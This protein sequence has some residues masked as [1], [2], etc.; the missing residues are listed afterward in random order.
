M[1]TETKD[2]ADGEN[3]LAHRKAI[4]YLGLILPW[5]LMLL[6]TRGLTQLAVR[7]TISDYYYSHFGSVFIGILFTIGFALFTYKGYEEPNTWIT[8]NSI[9]NI[10]GIAA[11]LVALFPACPQHNDTS[12]FGCNCV[13]D[14]IY[15]CCQYNIHGIST[16]T[17]FI[18]IIYMAAFKFTKSKDAPITPSK[19]LKNMF[20][21]ISAIGMG[22]AITLI[23]TF[24]LA[25][26][27]HWQITLSIEEFKPVLI[28]EIIAIEIF[29]VAWLV[30]GK[31]LMKPD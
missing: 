18:S 7:P 2:S 1:S 5:I 19:R 3:Y 23:A 30:K 15:I 14:S 26:K 4:G 27:M 11:I 25:K 29:A 17:F 6:D 31:A 24:F 9:S 10:A 21:K 16:A 8:D 13:A 28:L 20:Y 22:V 12:G